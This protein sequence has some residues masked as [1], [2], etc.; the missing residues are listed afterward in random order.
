MELYPQNHSPELSA[1]LFREPSA[2][3][4]GAPFWGWNCRLSRPLLAEEIAVFQRMGFGGFHIHARVGLDTP[5]LGEKFMECVRFSDREAKRRN[6]LCWLYDEDRFPSGFAGGQVTSDVRFRARQLLLSRKDDPA[7]ASSREEFGRRVDAGKKPR[8][9]Y[10]ASYDVELEHGRLKRYARAARQAPPAF[11]RRWHAFVRLAGEDAYYNGQTYVDVLNPQA[12]R[13]FIR[14]TH[15]R[16]YRALGPEFGR[17]VPAIFTDEPQLP[18]EWT[19]P[20]AESDADT[21][22]PFTDDLPETFRHAYGEDLLAG[23]PEI[24]WELPESR[25]STVRYHYHDHLAERFAA[26]YMDPIAAWCGAHG[27]YATGHYMSEP[28]LFSQTIRLGECMRLYRRFQLPGVDILCD[29]KEFSTLKQAASVARQCGREGVASE[30]YGVTNWDYD[31]KGHKLQGDW[32]AALGV[33]VRVPHLTHMT[34]AGEGKRD[35]PACIGYQ[36][37]WFAEYAAMETHFARLNTALTRGRPIVRVGVIHPIESYWLMFG[38]DDQTGAEREDY[39][40]QFAALIRWLLCGQIDFDFISESLLPRLQREDPRAVGAMRYDAV[41]VPDCRTLRAGTLAFLQKFRAGGGRV[42]FAGGVPALLDA[43]PSG[44]VRGFAAGCTAIRLSRSELLAAL[45]SCREI[46]L[47]TPA[48][49]RPGNL[50]YQLR[51][52]GGA[53]WLFLCH[54]WRK[55]ATDNRAETYRLRLRGHYRLTLF[56]TMTGES[57][58]YPAADAEGDTSAELSLCPQ[59]SLLLRLEPGPPATAG[60]K[61]SRRIFHPVMAVPEPARYTLAEPNVLLLDH[62]AFAFDNGEWQAPDGLLRIDNRFRRALGWP[63]RGE[64]MVQPYLLPAGG[65]KA[66]LLRLRFRIPSEIPGGP[67]R[68][69][70]EQPELASLTLNGTHVPMQPGGWY[71]DRLIRTVPLPPLRPGENELRADIRFGPRT[72]VENFYLLGSFGVKVAGAHAAVTAAPERL[73]FGD[74]VPQGLPFYG[75]TVTLQCPFS[76]PG[77]V[78]EAAVAI[79]HFTAP[80]VAVHMDGKR[81]G[82]VALSPH[83][84]ALGPLAAGAHRID[85]TVYGNRYNTFGTLHNANPDYKWYGPDAFRTTGDEWTDAYRLRTTGILGA[86]VLLAAETAAHNGPARKAGKEVSL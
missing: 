41:V 68:L 73:V 11:G 65:E 80:V 3:Y 35:W 66:H 86:P 49:R 70:L 5:Y 17:S 54:V 16:Y 53:R 45:E 12:V 19:L 21:A 9:Y 63:E 2:E 8:G 23:L 1:A 58:P 72:N 36:S 4:R 28:S 77:P 60:I 20:F 69:G 55:A 14:I 46:R 51:Q 22:I 43:K 56:D 50:I 61:T 71:V 30:L 59:D 38:P 29:D 75:G 40:A 48:G 76:L 85:F 42:I 62:A 44:L 83:R 81:A 84:L 47:T 82:S 25:V 34:L 32:Q 79:P 18:R 26:A 10:L 78:E 37:P 67:L 52:D 7:F 74:I 57:R 64:H 24:L 13:R 15:E 39:D 31:F 27:I 6:M 33:T